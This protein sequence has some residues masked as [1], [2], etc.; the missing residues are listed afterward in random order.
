MPKTSAS[1][2][3]SAERWLARFFGSERAIV[4]SSG[5]ADINGS[6]SNHE[7]LYLE[8]KLRNGN[9]GL[10]KFWIDAKAKA[11]GKPTVV[12]LR[13]KGC[14]GAILAVHS[15]D[16]PAVVRDWLAAQPEDVLL[17]IERD[18]RVLRDL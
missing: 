6:D 11:N 18:V 4:N 12:A 7:R 2:W 5:R 17:E 16:W 13:T 8:S 15:D 1:A 3:K 9:R 14:P 10:R